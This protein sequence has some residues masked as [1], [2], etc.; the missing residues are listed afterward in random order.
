MKTA[1]GAR[2]ARAKETI[3]VLVVRADRLGDVVLS[4]PVFQV[5][6]ENY[7]EAR[8]TVLVRP[9]VAPLLRGLES[10]DEVLVLEPEAHSGPRGFF[11]LVSDLRAGKFRIAVVLQS[12]WRV[13][14]A[15]FLAGVRY[16]VGPLSKLHSFL[17]YNR[18]LRQHRSQVEMHE[19]DYNLQLLRRIGIRVGSRQVPTAVHVPAE[20]REAAAQWLSGRGWTEAQPLIVVHP[21]MGGSAL[22]WPE[23][24]YL[25][26]IHA[27]LRE[28]R[29]V[30]VTGG[31]GE[32]PLLTRLREALETGQSDQK[33][34]AL[35]YGGPG[36]RGVEFLA[37]L[38]SFAS[39][40]VAPSTGPLHVA[41]AMGKPV[42][43]F[44]PPIRVQSAIRWGPYLHDEAL[45]SI[46]VPEM[47]C[48]ED[49]RCRGPICHYYPCMRSVLVSQA[50]EQVKSQLALALALGRVET[51][52]ADGENK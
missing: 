49:F 43:T 4:T 2:S 24:H 30:L 1:A 37:G 29:R 45:A 16:R 12:Q 6:K 48:G 9:E 34:R 5:I 21:G 32:E 51:S 27:L 50:H 33:E 26:L 8:L 17:F 19:A 14:L 15:I 42:V 47:Y 46:L 10:V 38:Y 18:G 44:Y 52:G 35:F 3:R 22:N 31:S 20:A 41:V 23:G 39:V 36:T 40:V 25:E 11:R 7:P 13:A 28:G